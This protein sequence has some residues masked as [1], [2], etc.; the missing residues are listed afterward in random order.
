MHSLPYSLT[1]DEFRTL[2]SRGN[3]IPL[4][5]EILADFETFADKLARHPEALGLGGVVRPG[6][7]LKDPPTPPGAFHH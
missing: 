2:A 3:L 7:G 1:F 5:R 4:Y 6:D